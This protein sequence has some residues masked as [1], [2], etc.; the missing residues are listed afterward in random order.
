MLHGVSVTSSYVL[1]PTVPSAFPIEKTPTFMATNAPAAQRVLHA[2][3]AMGGGIVSALVSLTRR[4]AEAGAVVKVLYTQRPDTPS[5]TEMRDR[6]DD[7]VQL[8]RLG[9][10]GNRTKNLVVLYRA[11]RNYLKSGEYD[12]LHLHSSFGGVVGRAA[13]K[14]TPSRTKTF[15]S[16]HGF[17]FLRLSDS[18]LQRRVF[19]RA[20]KLLANVGSLILV[21]QTEFSIAQKELQPARAYLVQTGVPSE[22]VADVPHQPGNGRPVVGMVGRIMY[23]KAPWRFAAAARA[24]GDSAD[25][26]WIGR[27]S[28]QDE[29]RWLGD[30]PVKVTGWLGPQDVART[31]ETLD[32]LLFPSLW[33]GKALALI[34]GQS[35][36]IPAVVSDV[37]GNRDTVVDEST[38]F[39]CVN[40]EELIARTRQLIDDPD[41]RKRMSQAAIEWSRASLTDDNLGS[42][43]LS[44]Y[45]KDAQSVLA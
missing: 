27:G 33:E 16:P 3:E 41:L 15:Y 31:L 40:D 42:E 7:R 22:L 10:E 25:F 19:L 13:A 36:G 8:E 43:S 4:Q 5:I 18:A 17:A 39:V 21:S 45:A 35:R 34:E 24:L 9:G 11:L 14:R 26:I 12:A 32:V 1:A 30:A 38:G 29:Q 37:V 23:Q 44:I 28:P 20:E 2:T 6:F